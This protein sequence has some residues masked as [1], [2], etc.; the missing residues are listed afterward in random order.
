[1]ELVHNE[2]ELMKINAAVQHKTL[3]DIDARAADQ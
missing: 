2:P 3:K 1:L